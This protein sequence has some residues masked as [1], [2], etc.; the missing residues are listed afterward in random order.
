MLALREILLTTDLSEAST[1]AFG[2]ARDLAEAAGGSIVLVTVVE[3]PVPLSFA[4]AEV[5]TPLVD[6]NLDAV[7]AEAR[8]QA[9]AKLAA[10]RSQVGPR[11]TEAIAISGISAARE[12]V[13]AAGERRS[14]LV[15]MATHGRSGLARVALGSTAE[16]VVREAPCPVL[17]VRS[18]PAG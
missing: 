16:R 12:I 2:L 4:T 17:T 6:P 13:R 18:R 14:D 3:D 8:R 7:V 1:A 5:P 11:C 10:L 9:E 15:V